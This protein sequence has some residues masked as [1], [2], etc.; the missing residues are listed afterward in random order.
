MF[1]GAIAESTFWPTQRTVAEMEFQYERLVEDVNCHKADDSLACLRA[2]DIQTTQVANVDKPFPGGNT[3]QVPLWYF[4]PVVD[5]SLVTGSLYDSF[6]RGEFVRVPLMVSDDTN[7]GTDFAYNATDQ[8]E[9]AQ[10]M[11]NNY[12]KLTQKQLHQ[13]NQVYLL[14]DPPPKHAAYFPSA[15]AAYGELTYEIISSL[16]KF[17]RS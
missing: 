12:P 6:S 10:F 7:E 5:G 14:M 4:L 1:S 3:N 8:A 15:S 2:A 13:I 9:V 17:V 16:F 11:K